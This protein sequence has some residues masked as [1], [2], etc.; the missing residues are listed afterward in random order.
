MA[1]KIDFTGNMSKKLAAAVKSYRA[2]TYE[3]AVLS[4]ATAQ[5]DNAIVHAI[6]DYEDDGGRIADYSAAV[7]ALKELFPIS[8]KD[9]GKAFR[10]IQSDL[11]PTGS[12]ETRTD[13]VIQGGAV[14][15]KSV[16]VRTGGFYSGYVIAVKGGGA[17]V[18]TDAVKAF[19]VKHYGA[20]TGAAAFSDRLLASIGAKNNGAAAIVTS[21]TISEEKKAAAVNAALLAALMQALSEKG[22]SCIDRTDAKKLET[23]AAAR[24][25]SCCGLSSPLT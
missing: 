22:V 1:K 15:E 14:V 5:R 10:A 2:A 21:G 25:R 12:S 13:T 17:A 4:E 8:F 24:M 9:N 11:F 6:A 23:A 19:L 3:K 20:D 16:T 7:K 18:F